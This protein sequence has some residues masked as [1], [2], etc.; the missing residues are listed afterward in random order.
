MRRTSKEEFFAF[1][2]QRLANLKQIEDLAPA[3]KVR[4]AGSFNPEINVLLGVALDALAK[5]WAISRNLAF[6][7]LA[8][9]FGQFLATHAGHAWGKCSHLDLLGR[10]SKE[11]RAASAGHHPNAQELLDPVRQKGELCDTLHQVLGPL[12]WTP[13]VISWTHDPDLKTLAKHAR[14]SAAGISRDWLRRSRYGEILYRHWRSGW[15]HA[16]DPDPELLT[17]YHLILDPDH[18]PHYV[19]HNHARVLAI[20]TEF[21]LASFERALRAFEAEIADGAQMALEA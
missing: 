3:Q 13:S 1:F 11:A 20:P 18:P 10:A 8:E 9:C 5:Y 15:I 7:T 14:I 21:I 4:T 6:P 12:V 19:L 16:L 17:E 2:R